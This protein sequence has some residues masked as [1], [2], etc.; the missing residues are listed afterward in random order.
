M[1][2]L[3][4][5]SSHPETPHPGVS[6]LDVLMVYPK[7]GS[8]DSMFIDLPLSI[9]YASAEAV[10]RG[11]RVA[12]LDL[13]CEPGDGLDAI[14][15]YLDQ[16]TSLVGISVMFGSPLHNSYQLSLFIR[17]N[18]PHVKIIW[19]GPHVTVVPETISESCVDF[20]VRG[21]GSL[22]LAEL[23]AV[24]RSES[25]DF[26][27]VL[28]LSYKTA[29]GTPVHNPRSMEFERLNYRDIPYH[30]FDLNHPSYH[31]SY[32]G[33]RM[34]SIFTSEG[35]PYKC[36]FCMT[37][38]TFKHFNGKRWIAYP[39]D[40]VIEHISF[41]VHTYGAK[42]IC[43][44]D[45]TSFVNLPRMRQLLTTLCT[46]KL[47][48]T[49]EFR[50]ARINELN[51]MDDAFMQLMVDAGVRIVM[52]GVESLSDRLLKEMQKG[53]TNEMVF[54]VNQHLAR[55]PQIIPNYNFIFGMPGETYEDLLET[56]EGILR[57]IH[58]NP[59][60]YIG[61]GSDW[62]PIPGSVMLEK[63]QRDYN[64]HVPESVDDWIAMDT[65][66]AAKVVHP[67]YTPAQN[68]LIKLLQVASFVIDDKVI[69]ESK[70][71]NTLL[72][73]MLRFLSRLYKPIAFFRLRT[74]FHALLVEY[75][76]WRMLVVLIY[77]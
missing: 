53:I 24:M 2:P 5:D 8:M 32:N 45:D 13:R 69:K 12:L 22:P 38:A 72:F 65:L 11:Y 42:H 54:K 16:G 40:E 70:G 64:F 56:K 75:Y 44:L 36:T 52:V 27:H 62:R 63:A 30:M 4:H 31:R 76:F 58:D 47:N 48:I 60:A 15:R 61:F 41:L 68:Q 74:N 23:I 55:F 25:D 50:G 3:D 9:I 77:R 21:K 20:L 73:I 7:L 26:S 43:V 51:K 57:I 59:M 39:E 46:R 71:N 1:H 29:A 19:G 34:F 6:N 28:G 37:P 66:D 17:A 10:K 14:K 67:W 18:Y 33:R 49:L 35:C